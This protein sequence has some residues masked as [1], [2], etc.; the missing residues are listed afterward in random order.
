MVTSS[1]MNARKVS[2]ELDAVSSFVKT[3]QFPVV[4][5]R[6]ILRHFRQFYSHKSAIDERKIFGEMSSALRR[7][8]STYIVSV[9][10]GDVKLFNTRAPSS[11]PSLS[12]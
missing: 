11:G 5:G 6:R 10:M 1:D 7:D 12:F 3:R 2:E 4:L 8:V 9:R